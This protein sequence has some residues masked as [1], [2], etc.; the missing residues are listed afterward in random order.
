MIDESALHDS[1]IQE[2]VPEVIRAHLQSAHLVSPYV[3]KTFN[4]PTIKLIIESGI[5]PEEAALALVQIIDG[6]EQGVNARIGNF[7]DAR[8]E[9]ASELLPQGE[10]RLFNAAYRYGLRADEEPHPR[11][12]EQSIKLKWLVTLLMALLII[13]LLVQFLRN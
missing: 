10:S 11:Q 12:L 6:F 8:D 4:D 2:L 5:K 13:S 9:A 3:V 7:L 1:K